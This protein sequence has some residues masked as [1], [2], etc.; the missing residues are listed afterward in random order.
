MSKFIIQGG[1]KLKGEIKVQ[2]AKNAATPC[3]SAALLLKGD[4]ILENIPYILDGEKTKRILERLGA[5][6][7]N[8]LTKHRVMINTDEVRS[9][10]LDFPEVYEMRSSILL[11]GPL[12]ARFG[13]VKIPHP[14]GCH[15]G[16]RSLDVHLAAFQALGARVQQEGKYYSLRANKLRGK[17][18][19]LSEFS[20]TAT[21]NLMLTA[22]LI[23][24]KT[25]IKLAASEPHVQ[26]L[27]SF[28]K[29]AGA[30][31]QGAGTHTITIEGVKK[32]SGIRYKII[33]DM[34]EAGTFIIAG[35]VTKGEI[36][37][38]SLCSDHLDIF[39]EKLK[40]AGACLEI[41]K[42]FVKVLPSKN[43]KPVKIQTLPYP[44][45]PTDLQ[46]PFSVLLTQARGESLIHDPMYEGRLKYL[47]E[48]KKMGAKAKILDPHRALIY[49]PTELR[50]REIT[51]FD[52]RA[53]ATL[54][55]AALAAQGRSVI[56]RAEEVDR[57]Y[58]RIEERLS[59]LGADI[60]R[61]S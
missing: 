10:P 52:L 60:K 43:F 44:G 34:I 46:A 38:V 24:G 36:K 33:P 16:A 59:A 19:I 6:I 42:D 56:H 31:I 8:D 30:K 4:S 51:S 12:L 7:E 29:R 35:L 57:G 1:K 39:L 3:L 21:E 20:V 45:F 55:L 2:G 48:L 54:I 32:L 37:V 58:E 40:M 5:R 18:I 47:E 28:L 53:G 27:A 17:E 15:I 13:R 9:R 25:V 22:C 61:V 23:P 49:G 11:I 50:G 26:D 41:G 14:G